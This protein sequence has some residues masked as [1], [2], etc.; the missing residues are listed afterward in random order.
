M[1]AE[2]LDALVYRNARMFTHCTID[3]ERF[4]ALSMCSIDAPSDRKPGV[5]DILSIY[6]A[7]FL[8]CGPYLRSSILLP[9]GGS[10]GAW[11]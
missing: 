8:G 11:R 6:H 3:F 4:E 10:L 5:H 2:P 7:L 1:L 9:L